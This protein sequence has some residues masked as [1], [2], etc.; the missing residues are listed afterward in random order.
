MIY[1]I[2][3]NIS[4]QVFSMEHRIQAARLKNIEALAVERDGVIEIKDEPEI[5]IKDEP[6]IEI[7]GEEEK[8]KCALAI[9]K[10]KD[11]EKE[12]EQERP[13]ERDKPTSCQHYC[14]QKSNIISKNIDL[15]REIIGSE[16][17][18]Q[19]ERGSG[20]GGIQ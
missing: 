17:L 14:Q 13:Q 8:E 6:E 4:A 19:V 9:K 15:K 1:I 20:R 10:K 16:L 12:K 7:K 2:V 18:G 3:C 11:K 5:E